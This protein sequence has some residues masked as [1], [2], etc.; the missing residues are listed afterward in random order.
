MENSKIERRERELNKLHWFWFGGVVESTEVGV[1][2]LNFENY[3]FVFRR[4]INVLFYVF[5][6]NAI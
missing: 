2:E 6:F 3:F 1:S 4:L 5:Q